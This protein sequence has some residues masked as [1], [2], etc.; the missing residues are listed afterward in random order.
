MDEGRRKEKKGGEVK[1]NVF[2][3][4]FRLIFITV[5]SQL[6][7]FLSF[8]FFFFLF[9]SFSVGGGESKCKARG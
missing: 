9:L 1:L 4:F 5:Y 6:F 3:S 7:F 8:S 2:F